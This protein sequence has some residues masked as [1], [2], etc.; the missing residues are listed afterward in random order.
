[1]TDYNWQDFRDS[2]L[3]LRFPEWATGREDWRAQSSDLGIKSFQYRGQ[4]PPLKRPRIFISHK[5]Q[6]VDIATHVSRIAKDHGL[7]VWLDVLD[8]K[9]RTLSGSHV[10]QGQSALLIAG[11]IE[12]ALLNCTQLV[13]IMTPNTRASRWVP[14]EYGRVKDEAVMSSD[15]SAYLSSLSKNQ[16]P[17]YMHLGSICKTD[18]DMELQFLR[19]KATELGARLETSIL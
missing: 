16:L 17:E 5:S 2:P 9:L 1:M 8:P 11:I 13:A 7:D 15:V 18:D 6:D 10:S 12:V 14:Y 4:A 3:P 19:W